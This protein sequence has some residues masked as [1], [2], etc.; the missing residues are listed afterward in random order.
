MNFPQEAVVETNIEEEDVKPKPKSKVK[1]IEINKQPVE[2]PVEP[3]VEEPIVEVVEKPKVDKLKEIVECPDCGL[4]MTQQT[5]TYI[6]K[7]R[8]FCKADKAEPEK[9]QNQNHKNQRLQK[10]L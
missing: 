4:E 9:R 5:S 8:G 6:H 10:I 2:E 7:R 3:I 1:Q